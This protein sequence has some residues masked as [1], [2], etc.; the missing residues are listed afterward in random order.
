MS[1]V[2]TDTGEIVESVSRSLTRINGSSELAVTSYLQ[3]AR[4]WMARAVDETGPEQIAAAR[5]EIATA[6]EATK[7]LGLTKEIQDDAQEMVRRAE[8]TL[9]RSIR[10]GQ[11]DGSIMTPLEAK[12]H[13][14]KV[15]QHGITYAEQNPPKAKPTDFMERHEW[16][17]TQGGISDLDA[18][19][20]EFEAV[21]AEARAEGNLSRANV[22]R[23]IKGK[24]SPVTRDQRV[25]MIRDLAD[26]GY[27]SP[28]IAAKTDVSAEYVR[29]I[30]RECDIEIAADRVMGKTHK[31]KS[32]EIAANTVGALEGLAMGVALI[33]YA[34]LDPTEKAAWADSLKHSLKVLNRF[35]NQIKKESAQ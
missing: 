30:A 4:D 31:H 2:N 27:S 35:A 5:A 11:A 14:G 17:N 34:D 23:K 12:S 26:Q 18:A 29:K 8:F 3:H 22:V 9:N 7:Q 28:Q 1:Y 19:P 25:D 21:L 20:D 13:A 24:S 15:R 33:D 16:N 10:R 32:N 6:A